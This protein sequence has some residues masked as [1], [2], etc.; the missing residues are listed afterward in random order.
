MSS[1]ILIRATFIAIFTS[2]VQLMVVAL[3]QMLTTTVFVLP[4]FTLFHLITVM[5]GTV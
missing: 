2:R 3:L 5:T 4:V 1:L